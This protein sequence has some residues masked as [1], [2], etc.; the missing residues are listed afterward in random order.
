V[1]RLRVR[2]E[3]PLWAAY[4][5]RVL[6]HVAGFP[7]LRLLCPI[8]HLVSIRLLPA[9]LNAPCSMIPP[10][11]TPFPGSSPL[12]VPTLTAPSSR[13]IQEPTGASRVLRRLSFCIPRPEDSGGHPRSR[14]ES[15]ASYCLPGR[16]NCRHPHWAFRSCTSTSRNAISPTAYKTL[17]VRLPHAV[18]R[19]LLHSAMGSTLDTG[20]SLALTRRGLA[21]R[22][23]R[24]A[25]L[26]AI[27][28]SLTRRA[29]ARSLRISTTSVARARF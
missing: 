5:R 24:Q 15:S 27:T 26:G 4:F 23:R 17:C 18:V 28:Y 7:N 25:S 8:R 13:F 22:K 20:G 12:R 1:F 3:F 29:P 10:V 11:P 21:P 6:R 9:C 2:H 14:D 16:K 19:G